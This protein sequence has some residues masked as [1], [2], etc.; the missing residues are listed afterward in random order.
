MHLYM[1]LRLRVVDG[2]KRRESVLK[3]VLC[4]N[5]L[6]PPFEDEPMCT[7]GESTHAKQFP[8]MYRMKMQIPFLLL[9]RAR[10][11][12]R[13]DMKLPDKCGIRAHTSACGARR[14]EDRRIIRD[15][16]RFHGS[17][18]LMVHYRT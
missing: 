1:E 14:A 12:S 6:N 7:L 17:I 3:R 16:E 8:R 15:E 2:T 4:G 11:R 5:N 13:D 18:R 10:T 9:A